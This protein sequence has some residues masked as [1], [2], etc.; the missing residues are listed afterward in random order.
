MR[1]LCKS[2]KRVQD[3]ADTARELSGELR[4]TVQQSANQGER[5][6]DRAAD[7]LDDVAQVLLLFFVAN[8]EAAL[9]QYWTWYNGGIASY[10]RSSVPACALHLSF[11]S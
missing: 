11:W 1:S 9:R 10:S 2:Q 6:A 7:A 5:V 4:R 3:P 8:S